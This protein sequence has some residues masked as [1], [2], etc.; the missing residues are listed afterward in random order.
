MTTEEAIQVCTRLKEWCGLQVYLIDK[1]PLDPLY[2]ERQ[3]IGF[4]DR[5]KNGVIVEINNGLLLWP[6]L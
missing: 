2:Q 1:N 5:N 4:K 6:D 3:V